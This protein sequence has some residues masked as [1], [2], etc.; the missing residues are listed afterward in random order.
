[1]SNK[2]EQEEKEVWHYV[3]VECECTSETI[4]V[5]DDYGKDYNAKCVLEDYDNLECPFCCT[6]QHAHLLADG[7]TIFKK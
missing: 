2:Q 4:P 1:M 3:I 6:M 7:K 5:S